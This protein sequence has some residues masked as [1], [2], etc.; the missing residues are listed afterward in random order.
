LKGGNIN[1]MVNGLGKEPVAKEAKP[2]VLTEE[3]IA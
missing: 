1:A 3:P 2:P